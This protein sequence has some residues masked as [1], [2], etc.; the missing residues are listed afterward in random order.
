VTGKSEEFMTDRVQAGGLQVAKVLFDFVEKE[1]LPGTDVDSE[2]FWAGA[3]SVIADLAP[4][5]KALL[6]VRDDIQAGLD[7]G[8]AVRTVW[9]YLHESGQ[10]PC[11]YDAFLSFVHRYIRSARATKAKKAPPLPARNFSAAAPKPAIQKDS[12]DEIRGFTFNPVP[13]KEDLI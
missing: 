13:R 8:Y 7:A 9:R 10:V 4:K 2:T 1:A 11:K 12:S 5:N 3:A 6:A